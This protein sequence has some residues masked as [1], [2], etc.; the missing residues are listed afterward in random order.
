MRRCMDIRF[1]AG[2]SAR[3]YMDQGF[4]AWEVQSAPLYPFAE[5]TQKQVA[6]M[7][8]ADPRVTPRGPTYIAVEAR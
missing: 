5:G 3:I 2:H 4:G 7:I 6:A 1:A 8:A